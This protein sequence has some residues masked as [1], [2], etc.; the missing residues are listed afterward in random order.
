[1]QFA[2]A[3]SKREA[4]QKFALRQAIANNTDANGNVDV[5]SAVREYGKSYPE[6][7]TNAL[8][9]LHGGKP[10][11]RDTPKGAMQV[12]PDGFNSYLQDGSAQQ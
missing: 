10:E 2:Q 4:D 11:L 3:N 12:Y 7:A 9:M 6:D 8:F 5:A 1:M